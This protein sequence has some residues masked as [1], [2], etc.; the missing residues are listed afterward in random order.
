MY[1][2]IA[3]TKFAHVT[4]CSE[5]RFHLTFRTMKSVAFKPAAINEYKKKK[6]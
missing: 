1:S 2:N 3:L 6:T 5:S 4:F